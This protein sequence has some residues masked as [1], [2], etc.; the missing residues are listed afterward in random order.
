MR[1]LSAPWVGLLQDGAWL[2][3]AAHAN[4]MARRLCDGLKGIAEVK[5]LFPTQAN[6]VFADL[7][8]YVIVALRQTGWKFYTFIGQGGCRL[9]CAWDTDEADVDQFVNDLKRLLVE[10]P[11]DIPPGTTNHRKLH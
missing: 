3:R 11:K 2:R 1:F 10:A 7:P 9:M 5:I 6:A 4:A 8:P